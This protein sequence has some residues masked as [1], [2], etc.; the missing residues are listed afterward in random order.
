VEKV[1]DAADLI[2]GHIRCQDESLKTES[3]QKEFNA[4]SLYNIVANNNCFAL[5]NR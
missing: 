1:N 2:L 4:V 3:V 5:H